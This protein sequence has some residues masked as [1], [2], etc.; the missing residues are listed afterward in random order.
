LVSW[1][2]RLRWLVS[3]VLTLSLIHA[4]SPPSG[5]E[6]PHI[7]ASSLLA[8]YIPLRESRA[9]TP[10]QGQRPPATT[11]V[12]NGMSP[13]SRTIAVS[14]AGA[15]PSPANVYGMDVSVSE[16][17]RAEAALH[18]GLHLERNI[19]PQDPLEACHPPELSGVVRLTYPLRKRNAMGLLTDWAGVDLLLST[20]LAT[21]GARTLDAAGGM[22]V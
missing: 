7:Q 15:D 14:L 10:S 8:D 17:S 5:E 11:A 22:R 3:C 1:A 16:D 6:Q 4:L 12:L 19:L 2:L 18:D 21:V 13:A 20:H 9:A